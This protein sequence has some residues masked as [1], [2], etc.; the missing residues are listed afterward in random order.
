MSVTSGKD[1]VASNSFRAESPGNIFSCANLKEFLLAK[2]SL[3]SL[4]IKRST[5]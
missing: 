1:R 5:Y 4:K 2:K 3:Y